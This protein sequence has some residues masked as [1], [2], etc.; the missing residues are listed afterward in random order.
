MN[1]SVLNPLVLLVTSTLSVLGLRMA[2]PKTDSLKNREDICS[3]FD[4]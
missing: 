2:F 3:L 4:Y 1:A